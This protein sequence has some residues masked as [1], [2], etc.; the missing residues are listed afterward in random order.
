[1]PNTDP[2]FE[3]NLVPCPHCNGN[4]CSRC[5][6]SGQVPENPEERYDWDGPEYD[7][8]DADGNED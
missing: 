8:Y 6:N 4:A 3:P 5:N 1:M 7:K 2:R